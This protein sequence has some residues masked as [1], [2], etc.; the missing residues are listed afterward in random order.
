MENY[1]NAFGSLFDK[2]AY[3]FLVSDAERVKTLKEISSKI[4]EY[5]Y[6]RRVTKINSIMKNGDYTT[7]L[8]ADGTKTIVKKAADE[9]DDPETA[10][11]YAI[12]KKLKNNNA[13]EVRR[14]FEDAEKKTFVKEKKKKK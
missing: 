6:F 8:W 1:N 2:M 13:S 3:S 4:Q 10:L 7:V 11:A 9:K 5:R 12:L 14:Y